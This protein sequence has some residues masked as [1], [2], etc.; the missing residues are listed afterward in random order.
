MVKTKPHIYV[1]DDNESVREALCRLLKSAGFEVET[2]NSA[3]SFLDSVPRDTQG[4]LI[5]DIRMPDM[6]GFELQKILN[7]R[8]S[9]LHIIFITAHADISDRDHAFAH[10]ADGF[11]IKPFNEQSLLD[12]ISSITAKED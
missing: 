2:F 6:D 8:H 9:P 5:L 11:L 1:V 10:G 4:I 7:E 12:L 3:Q